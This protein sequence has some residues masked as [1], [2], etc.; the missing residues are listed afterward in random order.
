MNSVEGLGRIMQRIV[1]KAY[2]ARTKAVTL[3]VKNTAVSLFSKK[4]NERQLTW[5]NR[6]IHC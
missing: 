4:Q 6:L 3:E 1:Q 5:Y 2:N